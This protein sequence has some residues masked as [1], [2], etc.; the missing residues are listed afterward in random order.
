[1]KNLRLVLGLLAFVAVT[2]VAW[3]QS[4]VENPHWLSKSQ[5][6]A[7]VMDEP[8]PPAPG[9][10]AAQADL[11]AEVKAQNGRTAAQ[12]SE[13]KTDENY[14]VA[15]FTGLLGQKLTPHKDPTTFRFFYQV[16][17]QISKVV[18]QSKEHWHRQR[19]YQ[20]HPD[21][22]HPLFEVSG[23]SYPS[24]HSTHSFAFALVL[25]E[26]FP[27]HASA[28]LARARQIAQSRVDAGVH[29]ETDIKEGEIVGREI[30]KD[31]QANP[32]FQQALNAAKAEVA[33]R[34]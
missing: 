24:G 13:A 5:I 21:V 22:I 20:A 31:L 23:F 33:A 27:D 18:G 2:T 7:I 1:M 19:P 11:Q 8:P 30:A 16:N 3:A 26:L 14:S 12:I 29:Y 34:K 28:F 9:S 6:D 17:K 32:E 10:A 25:G 4:D 15:L